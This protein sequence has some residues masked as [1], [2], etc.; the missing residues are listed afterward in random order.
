MLFSKRIGFNKWHLFQPTSVWNAAMEHGVG[1][2]RSSVIDEHQRWGIFHTFV[3]RFQLGG[4]ITK[5][6]NQKH[7]RFELLFYLPIYFPIS[8]ET[9]FCL[10]VLPI[11][12]GEQVV[13]IRWAG[14]LFS[15]LSQTLLIR[16][17]KYI[18][19]GARTF[20]CRLTWLHPPPPTLPSAWM[21]DLPT[22]TQGEGTQPPSLLSPWARV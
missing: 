2:W 21:A 17:S 3:E 4:K 19:I 14:K 22:W 5:T 11:Y 13:C 6:K 9:F 15:P 1:V 8:F 12:F 16:F 18:E 7:C 10:P 20:W